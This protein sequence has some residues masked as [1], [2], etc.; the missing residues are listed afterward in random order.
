MASN[1]RTLVRMRT[2]DFRWEMKEIDMNMRH[3]SANVYDNINTE[4]T[5]EDGASIRLSDVYAIIDQQSTSEHVK[6]RRKSKTTCLK[7]TILYLNTVTIKPAV[8]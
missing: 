4:Q 2:T 6:N 5:Y 1:S 8:K 3:F 7:L